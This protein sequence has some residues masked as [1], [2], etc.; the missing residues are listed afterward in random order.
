MSANTQNPMEYLKQIVAQHQQGQFEAAEAAYRGFIKDHPDIAVTY[1]LLAALMHQLKRYEEGITFAEIAVAKEP[2]KADFYLNKG[3]NHLGLEQYQEA[4]ECYQRSL[5]LAPGH[6]QIMRSLG[7]TYYLAKQFKEAAAIYDQASRTFPQ[8]ADFAKGFLD[9]LMQYSQ[10]LKDPETLERAKQ[11]IA[12]FKQSNQSPIL[13]LYDVLILANEELYQEAYEKLISVEDV[14]PHSEY[15]RLKCK[16][17]LQLEKLDDAKNYL[18]SL[19]TEEKID[20]EGFD[21]FFI[22]LLTVGECDTEFRLNT[23]KE[24]LEQD[25]EDKRLLRVIASD[26][27]SLHK[28][29][30]ALEYAQKFQEYYPDSIEGLY[31]EASVAFAAQHVQ[32]AIVLYNKI[33]RQEPGNIGILAQLAFAY[34]RQRDLDK[35]NGVA[36]QLAFINPDNASYWTMAFSVFT[37]TC[38]HVTISEMDDI[39]ENFKDTNMAEAAM[40]FL[41]A[42]SYTYSAE[43][44][45][46]HLEIQQGFSRAAKV[47]SIRSGK[48]RELDYQKGSGPLR[49]GL[50][51]SDIRAHSV[52]KFIDPLIEE[53]DREKIELYCYSPYNGDVDAIEQLMPNRVTHFERVDELSDRELVHKIQDHK[54]DIL[55]ELNGMTA[56]SRMGALNQRAAPVQIEWLGFPF[57][58]GM[59]NMDYM[60]LDSYL[61]P[62]N[63]ETLCEKSLIHPGAWCCFGAQTDVT[64]KETLP[65]EENGY[66]TFGTLNNLYKYSPWTLDLWAEVLNEVP[67]SKF[68]VVRPELHSVVFRTNFIREMKER[69]IEADRLIFF[70]NRLEG[71]P[72]TRCYDMIDICLD[73]YPLTGGTTTVDSLDMGVPVISLVGPAFHQR[74][75][76]AILRHAGLEEFCAYSQPEYVRLAEELAN[77]IDRLREYR[78]TIRDKLRNSD[79]CDGVG[80]TRGF[81]ELMWQ[82]AEKHDLR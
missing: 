15:W 72:H 8:E 57:T 62:D 31:L 68:V 20:I 53:H 25:P 61:T 54:I 19:L 29:R 41:S 46:K 74:I 23:Y 76:Y 30:E 42:L 44:T 48:A 59:E 17:L 21:E 70:N 73:T 34:G 69:G 18:L 43:D 35:A 40:A 56:H 50:L 22:W 77:D 38:D 10:A 71:V 80:F 11:L 64:V 9:S 16:L 51:S 32:Q 5:E 13:D 6:P 82:L 45:K 1:N 7:L 55:L 26:L 81:E 58:T 28:Y 66:I 63:E 33:L 52:M 24:F 78:N 60:L 4:I 3:S 75:S 37:A 36:K 12:L 79:L 2:E 67:D 14:L 49:I 27:V 65:F 39:W 47:A